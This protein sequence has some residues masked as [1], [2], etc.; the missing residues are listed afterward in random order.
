[1]PLGLQTSQHVGFNQGCCPAFLIRLSVAAQSD[2]SPGLVRNRSKNPRW[3]LLLQRRITYCE[4][5]SAE[6]SVRV[7]YSLSVVTRSRSDDERNYNVEKPLV[8]E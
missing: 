2:K 1:M 5:S 6:R 7:P 3:I 4:D 8:A